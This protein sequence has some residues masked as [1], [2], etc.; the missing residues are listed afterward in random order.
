MG[1]GKNRVVM[2]KGVTSKGENMGIAR[3]VIRRTSYLNLLVTFSIFGGCDRAPNSD[4]KLQ[5]SVTSETSA[6]LQ[7]DLRWPAGGELVYVSNEDS[8][9]ISIISTATNQVVTTLNVGRR[10]RGIRVGH[11]GKKV[12]VALSGSPK[13]PPS[14]S[15]EDCESQE[16][17]W[18][19]PITRHL[20][21]SSS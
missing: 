1:L 8:G 15:D 16:D 2:H 13:C 3:C 12:F 17:I 5:E 9:D 20:T 6:S 7:E 10:P 14:M 4:I 21:L 18:A 11:A 19:S